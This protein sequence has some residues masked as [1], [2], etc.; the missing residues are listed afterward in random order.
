[1]Y[2]KDISFGQAAA[3]LVKNDDDM[4]R[5]LKRINLV[6]TAVSPK[7]VA[8]HLRSIIQ[9]F[10][11]EGIALDHAGLAKDIYLFSYP[12]YASNVKLSW[13]RDFY[14]ERYKTNRNTEGE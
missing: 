6:A 9:L 1:M 4:E 11:S 7:D 10:K 12:E 8:Y 13:G 2:A 5:I 3:K 14:R